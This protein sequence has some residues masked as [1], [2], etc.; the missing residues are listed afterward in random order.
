MIAEYI[1]RDV[2]EIEHSKL[3]IAIHAPCESAAP[4]V[5][6]G[7]LF[8]DGRAGAFWNVDED[9]LVVVANDHA[10]PAQYSQEVADPAVDQATASG[11]VGEGKD[12]SLSSLLGYPSAVPCT[13]SGCG[14]AMASRITYVCAFWP[15]SSHSSQH[16][17]EVTQRRD[18]D[19]AAHYGAW[20]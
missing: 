14:V 18:G 8:P 13:S 4:A 17:S 7:E 5:E 11:K 9:E 3:R 20:K 1:H 15:E 6:P 10:A 12:C 2:H 16:L 19:A